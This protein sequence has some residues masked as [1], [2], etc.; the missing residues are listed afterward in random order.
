MAS[1]SPE[2]Q[3]HDRI[4]PD[5]VQSSLDVKHFIKG[6]FIVTDRSN[7]LRSSYRS[8]I[9]SFNN[10]TL[11]DDGKCRMDTFF[12]CLFRLLIH[13]AFKSEF[14]QNEGKT[15]K[16]EK[17]EIRRRRRR[18]NRSPTHLN[19]RTKLAT[20][21]KMFKKACIWIDCQFCAIHMYMHI[22]E[23]FVEQFTQY[24]VMTSQFLYLSYSC[25]ESFR[26]KVPISNTQQDYNP[27]VDIIR[28]NTQTIDTFSNN[29]IWMTHIYC[30][31]ALSFSIWKQFVWFEQHT[32]GGS[33]VTGR[34]I[35]EEFIDSNVLLCSSWSL[36][37]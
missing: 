14:T 19:S 2:Q 7:R 22:N 30:L 21:N 27:P 13:E 5:D 12:S 4:C 37:D 36:F 17:Q 16:F 31:F 10:R 20:P 18:R 33:L 11:D 28:M 3:P 15:R 34:I 8:R 29:F 26:S 25:L 32:I 35:K 24:A 9:V 1:K 6:S 23:T